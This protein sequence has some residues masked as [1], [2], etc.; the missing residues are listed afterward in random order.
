VIFICV[1]GATICRA[2]SL[3]MFVLRA[4]LERLLR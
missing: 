3:A 2:L 1:G 4:S